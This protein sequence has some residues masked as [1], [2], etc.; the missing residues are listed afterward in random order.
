M[1]FYFVA[2]FIF[3]LVVV[4]MVHIPNHF[5]L[6]EVLASVFIPSAIGSLLILLIKWRFQP[7]IKLI[8]S[9][10]FGAGYISATSFAFAIVYG[11]NS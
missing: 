3:S 8:S 7:M 6:G 4:N 11:L 10:M 9:F 1:F 2:V 5:G